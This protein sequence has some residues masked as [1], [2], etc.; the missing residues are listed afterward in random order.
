MAETKIIITIDEDGKITASTEGIKG[1]MCLDQLEELLGNA[2]SLR[3][4]MKTDE[5]YEERRID[6]NNQL[7]NKKS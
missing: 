5:F 4:I 7:Q 6:S 3:S 2:T 1:E